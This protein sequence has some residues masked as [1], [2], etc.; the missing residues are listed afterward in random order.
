MFNKGL[1]IFWAYLFVSSYAM[2]GMIE[3]PEIS[4]LNED[5]YIENNWMDV[6]WWTL[7]EF[8]SE[9]KLYTKENETIYVEDMECGMDECRSVWKKKIIDESDKNYDKLKDMK[10]ILDYVD[11][12]SSI[13]PNNWG[14]IIFQ[15]TNWGEC[16]FS[17]DIKYFACDEWYKKKSSDDK[18]YKLYKIHTDWNEYTFEMWVLGNETRIVIKKGRLYTQEILENGDIKMCKI[19]EMEMGHG[20]TTYPQKKEVIENPYYKA[21]EKIEKRFETKYE[22]KKFLLGL[23]VILEVRIPETED[24]EKKQKLEALKEWIQLY[25]KDF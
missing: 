11:N 6:N 24:L 17:D 22:Y 1:L 10:K 14:Y 21:L 8:S 9:N 4:I 3:Y 19:W 16:Y 25:L 13:S 2:A 20:T 7:W 23:A 5:C 18:E 12:I 15:T